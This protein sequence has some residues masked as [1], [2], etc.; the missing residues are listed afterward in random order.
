LAEDADNWKRICRGDADAFNNFYRESAPRLH[1]FLRH[2]VANPQAAEDIA[3]ETFTYL[4]TRPNGYDPERGTLRAYL[5]GIARK[6]AME[7]WR[8]QKPG[9][10]VTEDT[11]GDDHAELRSTM[12]DALRR[13]PE[14]QRTLLWLR[15]VEGQSYVELAAILEIPVGT[16]RSR[17]F[18][19]RE[20]LR[21]IWQ[22][23]AP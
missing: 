14:D 16:V 15:E 13:L 22:S 4:W 9:E 20:A 6:R 12:N 5:F 8:K 10:V 7:W 19:A 11:L 18:T 17:L 2:V 21:K 23:K 1:A 3:Q